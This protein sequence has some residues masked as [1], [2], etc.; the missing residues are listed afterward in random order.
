M[1]EVVDPAAERSVTQRCAQFVLDEAELLDQRRLEEWA[2]LFTEDAV[3]WWP[4]DPAQVVP[5]DG[6]NIVYDDRARLLDRVSR[7]GSGLAFSD[8]PNSA[9]N[10]V[11]SGV[12]VLR[13]E[14][15]TPLSAGR[16]LGPGEHVAVA[17]GL[18]GRNRQGNTDT[19]HARFVWILRE[20]GESFGIVMK[21]VD[22]LNARD[23]LPVL[24]VLL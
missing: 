12:R 3:Y 2:A 16:S 4:M 15:A 17:R 7:L 5:G 10:H 22:L 24:T 20:T 23:P 18:I 21:R 9:T 8:E 14:Q 1:T 13:L 11:L 19:L 6:L